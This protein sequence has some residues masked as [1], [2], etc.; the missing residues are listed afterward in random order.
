MR[1]ILLLVLLSLSFTLKSQDTI[2]ITHTNYTTVFSKEKKYPVLVEWWVT[3]SKVTCPQP[4]KRKDNF[5]PDPLLRSET[6]LQ[7]DYVNSGFDRGHMS[8]AADNLCQT[9]KEQDE[10]FYFSNMSPQY[11]SLNAGDWKTVETWTREMAK[12]Y[13]SVHVWSGNIGEQ[14]KIGRV[15]V[16]TECWKVIYIKKTN[17]WYGFMFDNK[18]QKQTGMKSHDVGVET[19]SRV[20]GFKFN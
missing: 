16:P 13:D 20:T 2:R 9:Q 17:E 15:S 10:C 1:I 6:D 8:P 3:K 7:K 11:H 12:T 14:K 18:N 19:V 4:L 5:Q